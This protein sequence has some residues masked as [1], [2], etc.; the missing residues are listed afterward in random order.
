METPF[1]ILNQVFQ[2]IFF[3]MAITSLVSFIF[4]IIKFSYA[5]VIVNNWPARIIIGMMFFSLKI[6]DQ[7][8]DELKYIN[9]FSGVIISIYVYDCCCNIADGFKARNFNKR[10]IIL[11]ISAIGAC[12]S[13]TYLIY[14]A[15]YTSELLTVLGDHINTVGYMAILAVSIMV[16]PTIF[17]KR[18]VLFAFL[19]IFTMSFMLIIKCI[20]INNQSLLYGI[21]TLPIESIPYLLMALDAEAK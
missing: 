21:T 6:W 7:W 16:F 13:M 12:T 2:L 20:C 15:R 14:L 5:N 3:T 11:S 8:V 18:S 4:S 9:Y 17:Y 19:P 1:V 10:E